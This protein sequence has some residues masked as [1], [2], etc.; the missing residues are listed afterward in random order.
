MSRREKAEGG[1]GFEQKQT[2][3]T[4]GGEGPKMG[5]FFGAVSYA[6][7]INRCGYRTIKDHKMGSFGN[8]S[9]RGSSFAEA[10]EDKLRNAERG[11]GARSGIP[12]NRLEQIG[13][14]F[15]PAGRGT[16]F[17]ARDGWK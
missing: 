9:K 5:S 8:F 16:K 3:A 1:N 4:M 15:E 13:M 7:R 17:A 6:M 10:L 14:G 12:P 11:T 2:K